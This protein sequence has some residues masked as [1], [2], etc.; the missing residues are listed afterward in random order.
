[1]DELTNLS[2]WVNKWISSSPRST[3]S[4][5]GKNHIDQVKIVGREGEPC[6]KGNV[7]L[8]LVERDQALDR[9]SVLRG[10]FAVGFLRAVAEPMSTCVSRYPGNVSFVWG[11][12]VLRFA[13]A[14]GT[15]APTGA[16]EP[17]LKL[18]AIEKGCLSPSL[19]LPPSHPSSPLVSASSVASRVAP[20]CASLH[21]DSGANRPSSSRRHANS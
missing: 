1:M 4:G 17:T 18:T 3:N 20:S 21:R 8:V 7:R 15:W 5:R 6:T 2:G 19:F 10:T 13:M 14:E 12:R 16:C 11:R 9:L